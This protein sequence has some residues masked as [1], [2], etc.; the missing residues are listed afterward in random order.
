MVQLEA[1]TGDKMCGVVRYCGEWPG[2]SN[3]GPA[4]AQ[5][6]GVELEEEIRGG[7]HGWVQ[8][9]ITPIEE[10]CAGLNIHWPPSQTV[11]CVFTRVRPR[12]ISYK[13]GLVVGCLTNK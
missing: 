12:Q 13:R 7:G 11:Q 1:V 3:N 9:S 2:H 5:W 8:V 6:C 10:D 4:H